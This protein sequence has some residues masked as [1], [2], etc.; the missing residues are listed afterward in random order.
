MNH[1]GNGKTKPQLNE[2]ITECKWFEKDE[3]SEIKKSTYSSIKHV[4]SKNNL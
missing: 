4:L 2:G 1:I 3:I